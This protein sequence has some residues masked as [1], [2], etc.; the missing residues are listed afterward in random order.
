MRRTKIIKKIL[1]SLLIAISTIMFGL[2]LVDYFYKPFAFNKT[3][4][5]IICCIMLVV[6]LIFDWDSLK[7]YLESAY[8]GSLFCS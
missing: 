5:I 3:L 2:M 1:G 7:W 6:Y 8:I 4:G